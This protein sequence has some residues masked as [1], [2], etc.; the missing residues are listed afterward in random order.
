MS[1]T[2]TLPNTELIEL[3]QQV[4]YWK[5]QHQRS[6]EREKQL[7]EIVEQQARTIREQAKEITELKE[8]NEKLRAELTIIKKMLFGDK[9][10]KSRKTKQH[11]TA[12]NDQDNTGDQGSKRNRG[13]QPGV[14]GHGRVT[15]DHLETEERFHDLSEEEKCCPIC[16]QKHRRLPFTEDSEEI[17][18]EI[19]IKRIMHRR[20]QYEPACECKN[21]AA[22]L[23]AP[24]PLK[25]FPRTKFSIDFWIHMLMEKFMYQR[26]THRSLHHLRLEGLPLSQGTITGGF[27][28]IQPMVI[29][30]YAAI[31]EHSR[32]MNHWHM[33]ETRWLVFAN[34]DNADQNKRWWL[35]VMANKETCVYIIDPTRSREV[36]LRHLGEDPQGIINSDRYSV[37]QNICEAII[38]AYCWA[39]LRRDFIRIHDSRKRLRPWAQEWIDRIAHIYQLN[40]QRL[41]EATGSAALALADQQLRQAIDEMHDLF[42]E[43]LKDPELHKAAKKVLE[44]LDQ[45]WDQYCTFVDHPQVPMDNNFAERK[46]RNPAVGRKNYYGSGST[47][48]AMLSAAMFTIFQT[49][50]L[51]NIHPRK[52]LQMYFR[53]CAKN[54]GS[55]PTDIQ[56]FLPWNL[57]QEQKADLSIDS[58]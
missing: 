17:T 18:I 19:I 42:K 16:A 39:H 15:H 14:K 32:S 38:F 13:Q 40:D 23:V 57:S 5:A 27:A 52:F 43:Q 11:K 41:K 50:I 55:P 58:S 53:E 26:P 54:Q 47:W 2:T 31:V 46:L 7:R 44:S 30:L 4:N 10:E 12:S 9:Q 29:P 6:V 51:H 22:L 56:P 25:L 45:R 49:L 36:I 33:D 21:G 48:T 3:R 35:W 34:N 28:K 37:Y 24:A 8:K 1:K 20:Y